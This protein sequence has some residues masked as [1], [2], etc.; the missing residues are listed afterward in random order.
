MLFQAVRLK[1]VSVNIT[2]V[3][4]SVPCK[5]VC[6]LSPKTISATGF[7]GPFIR[8]QNL[9]RAGNH[10]S[11]VWISPYFELFG[12]VMSISPVKML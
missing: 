8:G 9:F 11:P 2:G 10:A 4:A 6:V 12:C 1:R 7:E 3:R 5:S